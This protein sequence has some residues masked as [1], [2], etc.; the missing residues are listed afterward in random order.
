MLCKAVLL[1]I[2]KYAVL[3]MEDEVNLIDRILQANDLVQNKSVARYKRSIRENSNRIQAIDKLL[4][5]LYEDK[6]AGVITADMFKRMAKKY[7]EEQTQLIN[8]TKQ[9]EIEL[10]ECRGVQHDMSGLVQR[11]K[12]CLGI[13]ALTREIVVE[14]IDM[15]TVSETYNADGESN[16]DIAIDYKFG[17]I[18]KEPVE[19][20]S[21]K[22]A[23][24]TSSIA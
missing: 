23:F 9:L 20:H 1:D 24:I 16:I 11:I 15:I 2:Q 14:L 21:A 6:V 12:D 13:K 5:N 10:T 17:H 8:D 19:S 7:N 3:A 18:E 4:Q 22:K